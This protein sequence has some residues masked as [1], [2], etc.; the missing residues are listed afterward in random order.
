[1][2]VMFQTAEVFNQ[3]IG[4][5]NVNQVT[6]MSYMFNEAKAFNQNIGSWNVDQVIDMSNMFNGAT[7]LIKIL[8]VGMS[9][10]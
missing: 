10:K 3:D 6:D 8:V 7:I 4:G 9:A 2:N 5:W 1:M